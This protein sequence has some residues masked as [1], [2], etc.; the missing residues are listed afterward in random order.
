[1]TRA[2]VSAPPARLDRWRI[3]LSDA[4]YAEAIA[5]AADPAPAWTAPATPP[6]S[7]SGL[8]AGSWGRAVTGPAAPAPEGTGSELAQALARHVKAAL[9]RL[10][11]AEA[12]GVDLEFRHAMEDEA[13]PA[14]LRQGDYSPVPSRSP[15]VR[16]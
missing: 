16:T 13:V 15:I 8:A 9:L 10:R 5:R 6:T 11:Q 1:V 3:G 7:A 4:E 14:A 12:A 2:T